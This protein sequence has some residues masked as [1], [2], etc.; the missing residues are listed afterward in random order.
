[1]RPSSF[2]RHSRGPIQSL[3]PVLVSIL[4]VA[5]GLEAHVVT[6]EAAGPGPAKGLASNPRPRTEPE[7]PAGDFSKQPPLDPSKDKKDH[8]KS[9]D[10]AKSKVVARGAKHTTYKNTDGTYTAVVRTEAV[11]WNDPAA[12]WKE[13]QPELV[14]VGEWWKN[15]SGA[16]VVELPHTTAPATPLASLTGKGWSIAFGL[17]GATSGVTA[18]VAGTKA[19]YTNLAPDLDVE[20]RVMNE[21]VKELVTLKRRPATGEDLVLR[22]PLRL[23]GVTATEEPDGSIAFRSAGREKVA[24]APP[25]GAWDAALDPAE[26]GGVAITQRLAANA[27]TA[28]LELVVPGAWL[29][30]PARK[31]PVTVDPSID[32]GHAINSG[33]FDAFA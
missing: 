2:P 1:M 3:V 23:A 29:S 12:G 8:S 30:D 9:F 18:T 28:A 11:N 6:A 13:I 14:R 22:F 31:Y 24:V 17:E 32:A 26:G 19:T 7:T 16:V 25:A 10:P 4:V 21:G 33:Q 15:K 27:N 20:E 5:T